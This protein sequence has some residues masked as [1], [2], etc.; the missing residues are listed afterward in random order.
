LTAKDTRHNIETEN[1]I[2]K[3]L[4][5]IKISIS[6]VYSISNKNKTLELNK[7]EGLFYLHIPLCRT[8]IKY[9]P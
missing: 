8:I 7:H 3:T 1:I 4:D 9:L 2:G 6:N 5:G